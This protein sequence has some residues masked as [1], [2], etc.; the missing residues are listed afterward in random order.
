MVS[1]FK[2]FWAWYANYESDTP[3]GRLHEIE[4]RTRALELRVAIL[5]RKAP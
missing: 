2:K 3:D 4:R 5:E 1:L